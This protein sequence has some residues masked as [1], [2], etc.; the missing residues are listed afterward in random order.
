MFLVSNSRNAAPMQNRS[1]YGRIEANDPPSP[2]IANAEISR[3]P[4]SVHR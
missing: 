4:A 2:R 1:T 3:M